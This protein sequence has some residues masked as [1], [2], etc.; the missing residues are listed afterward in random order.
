MSDEDFSHI[1]TSLIKGKKAADVTLEEEVDRNWNEIT[2]GEY[3]FNRHVL[4]IELLE[5]VDKADVVEYMNG[6]LKRNASRRKLSV[7]VCRS[8]KFLQAVLR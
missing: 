7:Q 6:F 2:S 1:V 8:F 5:S 3:L 4:E